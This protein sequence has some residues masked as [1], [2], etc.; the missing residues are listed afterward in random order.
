MSYPIPYRIFNREIAFKIIDFLIKKINEIHT[1]IGLL[2][3]YFADKCILFLL[4]L[5][6]NESYFQTRYPTV[7][8]FDLKFTTA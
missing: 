5:K 3:Q 2:Y 6:S 1:S 7:K 4:N 8:K